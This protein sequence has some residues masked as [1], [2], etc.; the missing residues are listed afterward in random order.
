MKQ[1]YLIIFLV[2]CLGMTIMGQEYEDN[3][4]SD[5]N[6]PQGGVISVN[7]QWITTG[8]IDKIIG[9]YRQQ[10]IRVAPQQAMEAETPEVRINIA[11][12]LISNALLIQEAKKRD[13]NP[14]DYKMS[15]IFDGIEH[16]FSDTLAMQ[17][18]FTEMGQTTETIR[19]QIREAMMVDSLMNMINPKKY[20]CVADHF[21]D[22]LISISR[23]IYIDTTYKPFNV[24]NSDLSNNLDTL[25]D[26]SQELYVTQAMKDGAAIFN[27]SATIAPSPDTA[28]VNALLS[29]RMEDG[30]Q[31]SKTI[32]GQCYGNNNKVNKSPN[33]AHKQSSNNSHNEFQ[34][35]ITKVF[36]KKGNIFAR[37]SN[38]VN[39][40]L[41]FTGKDQYPSLSP[42]CKKLVFLRNDPADISVDELG[43]NVR[44]P[45]V[46]MDTRNGKDYVTIQ[47]IVVM[48]ITDLKENVIFDW[49][50]MMS[51][52]HSDN[53]LPSNIIIYLAK[54]V[55]SIDNKYVYFMS[56]MWPVSD[57]VFSINCI[58]N[59]I[60]YI[61]P[62][63]S[64]SV[65]T[66]GKYTGGL[67]IGQ[68]SYGTRGAYEHTIIIDAN[69]NTLLK[70]SGP[71]KD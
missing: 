71:I 63:N 46:W 70:D 61:T 14:D 55:L 50:K 58:T 64:L 13:I 23:I 68:H 45:G 9:M 28:L 49:K 59:Q 19:T 5:D 26:T 40:Q 30:V 51:N 32:K 29:I 17:K 20:K 69:T 41:T 31:S 37:Y 43:Q 34:N 27:S 18:V 6:I 47:Q 54:P 65:I 62:G 3:E 44:T 42:D 66:K 60:K 22:S 56:A 4:Y 21:V 15:S 7:G 67:I 48:D 53:S 24:I 38:G 52:Y 16:Q 57:A 10:I 12:Q 25:N 1:I 2:L 11:Q 39:K 35:A 33:T 8:E 36:E